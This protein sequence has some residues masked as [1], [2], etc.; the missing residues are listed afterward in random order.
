MNGTTKISDV[1]EAFDLEGLARENG[2]EP[3]KCP[4][5]GSGMRMMKALD[6]YD[7]VWF[8]RCVDVMWCEYG[9]PPGRY[10]LHALQLHNTIVEQLG[11]AKA[12]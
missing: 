12:K 9:G 1:G 10:P 7:S 4:W 5:C 11:K 8:M 3:E 6:G 2:I